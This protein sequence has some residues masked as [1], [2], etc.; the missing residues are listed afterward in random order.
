MQ[1]AER[2]NPM[3]NKQSLTLSFLALAA[4]FAPATAQEAT[5]PDKQLEAV[6]TLVLPEASKV[7]ML[8]MKNGSI[9]WGEIRSHTPDGITFVRLDSGGLATL[10]WSFLD[11]GQ[12]QELRLQ[13]GYVDLEG[14][15]VMATADRIA[16]I[17]GTEMT[18]KILERTPTTLILKTAFSSSIAIP[19]TRVRAISQTTVPASDIYTRDELYVQDL[20]TRDAESPKDHYEL[21]RFCERILDYAHAVQHYTE[22]I[23]LDPTFRS[24]ELPTLLERAQEKAELQEQLDVLAEIDA[25]KRRKHFDKAFDLIAEF[26]ELYPGSPLQEKLIRLRD[27]VLKARDK[28]LIDAVKKRWLY[29]AGRLAREAAL[30]MPFEEAQDYAVEGLSEEIQAAV[31]EHVSKWAR[32]IPGE[33]V[34]KYWSER[35]KGRF[36][37]ITYGT[38]TWLL[39]EADALKGET[40]QEEES[41]DKPLTAT[42]KERKALEEKLKVFMDNRARRQRNRASEDDSEARNEWWTLASLSERQRWI[43]AF[44]VEKAGDFEVKEKPLLHNCRVC[45]GKGVKEI[46]YTGGA[47]SGEGS[48]GGRGGRGGRQGAASGTGIE[49]CSTCHGIGRTRRI[50][51]R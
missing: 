21:A 37:S 49:E 14:D 43:F 32:D 7:T 19:V 40:P 26:P 9:L 22:A 24:D 20:V 10:N 42:Q 13:Y 23:A 51:Y 15:E 34:R 16:L 35:D 28:F 11:P 5:P 39:G 33:E 17:D 3:M 41:S 25:L 46:I 4:N 36:R 38:G 47:R 31:T 6:T 18:G 12:E 45:G 27:Q 2:L 8:R 48:G 30:T 29:M 44:Y 50:Q 1:L